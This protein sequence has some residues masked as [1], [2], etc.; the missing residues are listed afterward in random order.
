MSWSAIITLQCPL[1]Q[2]LNCLPPSY[3]PYVIMVQV[4][5]ISP[6][7]TLAPVQEN[8]D[9]ENI[10]PSWLVPFYIHGYWSLPFSLTNFAFHVSSHISI[11][12]FPIL[13]L[14]EKLKQWDQNLKLFSSQMLSPT[15]ICDLPVPVVVALSLLPAKS[16][17]LISRLG[18]LSPI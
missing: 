16:Y 4:N 5:L 10:Q 3:I 2:S 18:T 15:C 6:H 1:A 7:C 8:A 14:T 9:T 13:V 12:S 17:A 11:V